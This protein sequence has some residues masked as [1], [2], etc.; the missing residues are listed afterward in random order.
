MNNRNGLNKIFFLE[1]VMPLPGNVLNEK[2]CRSRGEN[3][4]NLT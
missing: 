4:G 3:P 2:L 1:K